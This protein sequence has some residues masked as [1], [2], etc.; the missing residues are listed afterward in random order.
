MICPEEPPFVDPTDAGIKLVKD[1][2]EPKLVGLMDNEKEKRV[3]ARGLGSRLL[4]P[5]RFR[6]LEI[7]VIRKRSIAAVRC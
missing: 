7:F 5:E 6:R 1:L 3:V 4:T 2:L